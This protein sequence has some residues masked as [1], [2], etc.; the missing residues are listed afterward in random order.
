MVNEHNRTQN[1]LGKYENVI[2]LSQNRKHN[3]SVGKENMI[4]EL[5]TVSK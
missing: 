5:I 4:Y 2:Q 1:M 3:I